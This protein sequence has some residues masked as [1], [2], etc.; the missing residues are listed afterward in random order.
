MP[1]IPHHLQIRQTR[2]L[3]N[4]RYLYKIVLVNE[5]AS[6]FKSKDLNYVMTR[7]TAISGDSQNQKSREMCYQIYKCL[8]RSEDFNLRVQFPR[9]TVY[10]NNKK[11]IEC[12]SNIDPENIKYV[13]TINEKTATLEKGQILM[14]RTNYDYKV[15]LKKLSHDFSEFINWCHNNKKIKLTERSKTALSSQKSWGGSFFYVKG[16]S[17]LLMVKIF[18]NDGIQRIDKIIRKI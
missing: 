4:D 11:T 17:A 7:L 6:W 12:L 9:I 13:S 8:Y 5:Y 18:L 1:K 10:T 3:F 16:D 2:K 14:E 15:T